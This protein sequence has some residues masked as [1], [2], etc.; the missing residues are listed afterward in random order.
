[1]HARRKGLALLFVL[2]G[3]LLLL[4]GALTVGAATRQQEP[5]PNLGADYIG[6]Q[7]CANCHNEKGAELWDAWHATAHAHMAQPASPETVLGDLSDEAAPTIIWP[8][9]TTRPLTL[10][11]IA[12]TLGGRYIQRYVT[13]WEDEGGLHLYVLPV[14]W[15]IPQEEGQTGTW[16]PYH[17]EDW[18][19]PPRDWR[20]ACAACHTTGLDRENPT[21]Q[22]HFS[23]VDT[24][25]KGDVELGVGCEACHG[26]AGDHEGGDN[27]MPR[28]PD[29]QVCGQCH[30]Q[31]QDPS[32]EHGYPIGY[33]PG[34]A[35][36]ETVFVF[37]AQNDPSI[38]WADGHARTYNQYPEWRESGHARALET[39]LESDQAA[40]ECLRCHTTPPDTTDP[41]PNDE[42]DAAPFT[43]ADAQYGVTC[44]ACHNPHASESQPKAPP[45]QDIFSD[46]GRY[47][48]P[49]HVIG[50]WARIVPA[51]MVRAWQAAQDALPMLLQDDPYTLCVRCHNSATT[52]GELMTVEGVPHHPVQEM[53][54]GQTLLAEVEG[55]PSAHF[56]EAEG[57]RCAT[58]HMPRTVRIGEFGRAG[59]HTMTPAMP[60]DVD[61]IEPDSC[62]SCHSE[63][64]TRDDLQ[65]FL[66][67]VQQG[68]QRR[69]E[70]ARAALGADAPQWVA[71]ALAIVEGDGSLGV[72]NPAYTDALLDAVED[73]LGIAPSPFEPQPT[74]LGVAVTPQPQV[75][76]TA[77]SDQAAGGLATP[78]VVL[79][80][81]VGLA[82]ALGAYFFFGKEAAHE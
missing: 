40:E 26:P 17:P 37:A 50:A 8:D 16:T 34:L 57:P 74:L 82:L 47:I 23:S 73:A 54:E 2:G 20:V 53:F 43:L 76:L 12:Y 19:T 36:D 60:G 29:A 58:C 35:L 44:A 69:L 51:A 24:W 67:D 71:V 38:W 46:D 56:Q 66:D 14:Q 31:G 4:S 18:A 59:S 5:P 62:S 25:R 32:G 75:P 1:M 68:T 42:E 52:E 41:T 72:H 39:L 70:T 77:T 33:Q 64:V 21:A 61:T 27:P 79:L 30:S 80:G 55:V 49:S 9:G 45:S 10:D 15:N 48:P 81:V 22:T 13:E 65:R 7:R 3:A 78:S 6:S 28:T 11:D 63:L